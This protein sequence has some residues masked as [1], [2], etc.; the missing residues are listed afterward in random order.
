LGAALIQQV[1]ALFEKAWMI[2]L[3]WSMSL[4]SGTNKNAEGLV[5][6]RSGKKEQTRAENKGQGSFHHIRQL[7]SREFT[8]N[9]GF[10]NKNF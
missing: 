2:V 5:L 6:S 4:F 9:G 10:A 1:L 3:P 7:V 8:G